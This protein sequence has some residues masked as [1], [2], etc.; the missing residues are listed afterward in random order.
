MGRVRRRGGGSLPQPR[1]ESPLPL[2]P[3]TFGELLDAAVS[4]L[5]G[6]ALAYLAVG[7]ALAGA[8]QA[9][10]YPLRLAAG[11]RPPVGPPFVD[12]LGQFWVV[13]GVGFGTEAAII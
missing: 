10:L 6:H 9:V 12:R 11:I 2:R 3:L 1:P 4:L 5:R 7:I 13:L 8:E